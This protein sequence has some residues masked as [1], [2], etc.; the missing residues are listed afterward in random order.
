M[1]FR[2]RS[3]F[4]LI[5]TRRITKN[6]IKNMYLTNAILQYLRKNSISWHLKDEAA[7]E[8]LAANAAQNQAKLTSSLAVA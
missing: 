6:L 2:K 1:L 3:E 5:Q 8:G 7:A 4:Y